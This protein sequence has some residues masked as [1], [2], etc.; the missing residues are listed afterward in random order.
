[1]KIILAIRA[2]LWCL[3]PVWIVFVLPGQVYRAQ[4]DEAERTRA[5]LAY[6]LSA[7]RGTLT[8]Q[9][10]GAIARA[11]GRIA[12][13]IA[14]AGKT[15]TDADARIGELL[16]V[17]RHL[18]EQLPVIADRQMDR[19]NDSLALVASNAAQLE[20]RY[21]GLP[22]EI[23]ADREYQGL[24]AETMGVLGA[25]KIT[26]GQAAKTAKVI[27]DEAP[28]MTEHAD[29]IAVDVTREAD[30]LTKPQSFWSALR[31][32]LLTVAR[33]YGAL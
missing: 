16:V 22:D 19:A 21:T 25:T 6:E 23:R 12:S 10:S 30:T 5:M 24:V 20:L 11:N 29:R 8:M 4:H 27:A 3:V 14:M 33:I 26:M 9:L 13:A 28:K 15:E 31:S 7:T 32:W 18:D 1:M 2:A 17:A